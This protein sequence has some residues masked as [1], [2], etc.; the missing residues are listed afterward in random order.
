MT[1][2][3]QVLRL[4]YSIQWRFNQ[5]SEK[6]DPRYGTLQVCT[7]SNV[8]KFQHIVH[9]LLVGL[10]KF[11]LPPK[12]R[13]RHRAPKYAPDSINNAK[14]VVPNFAWGVQPICLLTLFSRNLSMNALLFYLF[15]KLFYVSL[16]FFSDLESHS[17][18]FLYQQEGI[19]II[20]SINNNRSWSR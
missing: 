8:F 16:Q 20:P 5:K 3:L 19:C 14:I 13:P 15:Y 4:A 1:Q 11:L 10:L 18:D 12:G 2:H 7:F 9:V 17:V 6:G